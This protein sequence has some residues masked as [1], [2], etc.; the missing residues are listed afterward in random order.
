MTPFPQGAFYWT[1]SGIRKYSAI[2]VFQK[3][4]FVLMSKKRLFRF[5]IIFHVDNIE[6]CCTLAFVKE[7]PE[8]EPVS[9]EQDFDDDD[10]L[11]LFLSPCSYI[12]QSYEKL[13]AFFSLFSLDFFAILTLFYMIFLHCFNI[14][15]FSVHRLVGVLLHQLF[16]LTL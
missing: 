2:H 11:P 16:A 14:L 5:Q 1:Y 15:F 6:G 3:T 12:I 13:F 7:F 4:Y 8:E 9:D 10:F